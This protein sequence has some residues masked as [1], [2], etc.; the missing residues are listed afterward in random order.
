MLPLTAC[1][2]PDAVTEKRSL[3]F[4]DCRPAVMRIP[5][6]GFVL[7]SFGTLPNCGPARKCDPG[8]R[9]SSA[10]GCGTR[11]NWPDADRLQAGDGVRIEPRERS[12]HRVPGD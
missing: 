8:Q 11:S 10:H 1:S 2:H 3:K 12:F 6:T 9:P 7:L 4:L 5:A